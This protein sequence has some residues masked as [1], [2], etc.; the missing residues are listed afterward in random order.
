MTLK[1]LKVAFF[2]LLICH[3]L[4]IIFIAIIVHNA[5]III[6]QLIIFVL[7]LILFLKIYIPY[8]NTIILIGNNKKNGKPIF[9]DII[10]FF[11][12]MQKT[13][14]LNDVEQV[15]LIQKIKESEAKAEQNTISI[16]NSLSDYK[17]KIGKA[18]LPIIK[19]FH[20]KENDT[21]IIEKMSKIISEL[22]ENIEGVVAKMKNQA[23]LLSLTF[24][25]FDATTVSLEQV[26]TIIEKAKDLSLDL[27]NETASGRDVLGQTKNGI[28]NIL[29]SSQEMANIVITI[30]DI[31]EQTNILS[32]NAA[33]ESSHTGKTGLGFSI[34]AKEIRKLANSTK[35]SSYEIK[36]IIEEIIQKIK[37]QAELIE[38]ANN[39]FAQI[40]K[41]IEQTS[42][43]NKQIYNISKKGVIL[44]RE[45]QTAIN[46]LA[47]IAKEIIA[48]SDKELF[49]SHEVINIMNSINNIFN[50]CKING[51][52]IS[53]LDNHK[54][55]LPENE[56][57]EI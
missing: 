39:I 55:K 28:E 36:Q 42:D 14:K 17:N 21:T 52:M 1:Y 54:N 8:K 10:L 6:S 7:F 13:I 15:S 33:I 5:F 44:G 23:E 31:S 41:Y 43:I 18:M 37:N 38:R 48:S 34:I 9:T 24:D 22:Y 19:V 26:D 46:S 2:I 47:A 16:Q 27:S 20:V 29:T 53:S 45:M 4:T 56:I 51:D 30:E 3:A 32:L 49:Q 35:E 12:D 25:A 50:N 11:H 40:N 57:K